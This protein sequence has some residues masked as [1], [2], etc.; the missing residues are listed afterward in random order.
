MK[1]SWYERAIH[2]VVDKVRLTDNKIS[3]GTGITPFYQLL[4]QQLFSQP[5]TPP[6]TRFTLLHSS[7]TPGE[8]PPPEILEPIISFANADPTRLKFSLYVDSLGS[9]NTPEVA[10]RGL[11][12]GRIARGTLEAALGLEVY[13]SWWKRLYGWNSPSQRNDRKVLFLVCGPDP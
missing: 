8:L 6:G 5:S 12:E 4:H 1:L 3:G 13:R 11:R 9:D 10:R 2:S 7:R